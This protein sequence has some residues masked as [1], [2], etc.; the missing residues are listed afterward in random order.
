MGKANRIRND[1][2]SSAF[3]EVKTPKKKEGMPSWAVNLI[4][5][6]VAAVI[7]FSVVFMM[8]VDNGV[9]GRMSTA[10][11]S[12]NFRVSRNMMNYYFKTQYQSLTSNE[13]Y[14][15]AI[16]PNVSLK[17]QYLPAASEGAPT[18]TWFDYIMDNTEAQVEELLVFCEEAK[19]RGIEL[20]KEDLDA[21]D[22]Q[23][24]N[25]EKMQ[26]SYD[27]IGE[28]YG[29][30]MK[31]KDL[32]AAVKLQTLAQKCSDSIGE[33]L[34]M[35]ITDDDILSVYSEDAKK[36][37]AV[38]YYNYKITVNYED[39][40]IA[41]LGDEYE[42]EDIDEKRDDIIAEYKRM[43]DEAKEDAAELSELDTAD[44]FKQQTLKHMV[45]DEWE[46]KYDTSTLE[47]ADIT[48]E[49]N[50]D[51]IKALA[52]DYVVEC[53]NEEAE[54]AD[55][56]VKDGAV[57]G[58]DEISDAYA[59]FI[60]KTVSYVF[61]AAKTTAG[62]MTVEGAKYS[63]DSAEKLLAWAFGADVNTGSTFEEGDG[64]ND[65]P[66]STDAD[67]TLVSFAVT[68]G[69][70]TKAAYNDETITR[71]VGIMTFT[72]T[73]VAV[74]AISKLSKGMSLDEFEDVCKEYGGEFNDLANYA[75]GDMGD[76]EFDQWLYAEDTEIGSVTGSIIPIGSDA[77]TYLAAI[78]YGDG[79]PQWKVNVKS[80]IFTERYT[81]EKDAIVAKY[82]DTIVKKEKSINKVDA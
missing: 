68:I 3:A 15:A 55:G 78:Y 36:Y 61:T 11:R 74:E 66:V 73:T 28:A 69:Y 80:N 5:I 2:Y 40:I 20:D 24:E 72:D 29:K 17:E 77:S 45:A 9:F 19:V 6:F 23:L 53:I 27:Y 60:K 31:I 79:L 75:E 10:M 12:D 26:A 67:D 52:I 37:Q 41:V 34:E 58:A 81:A 46:T 50:A 43:I 57:E 63:E 21:I 70:V 1:R 32:R 54:K 71:N 4:A 65:V 16:N 59:E 39:A 56:F 38:D 25:L 35:N 47:D 62:T 44:E 48:T 22:K 42:T 33:K 13:T 8:M 49:E 14:A 7:L 64:A 51:K 30:G 76:I 82:T 18:M